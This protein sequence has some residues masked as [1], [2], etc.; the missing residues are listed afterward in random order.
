MITSKLIVG[1]IILH[2]FAPYLHPFST[3]CRGDNRLPDYG[4]Q[5]ASYF[6]MNP[7]YCGRVSK[8]KVGIKV[9]DIQSA[10]KNERNCFPRPLE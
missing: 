9:W 2:H 6:S 1:A 10:L 7:R 5:A 8:G 3:F 4:P